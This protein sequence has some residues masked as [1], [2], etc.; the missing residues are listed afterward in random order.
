[1]APDNVAELS[2]ALG[3]M[4]EVRTDWASRAGTIRES[5]RHRF[6]S[7]AVAERILSCYECALS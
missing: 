3:E 5:T 6:D 7:R 1:V 4:Y 2:R